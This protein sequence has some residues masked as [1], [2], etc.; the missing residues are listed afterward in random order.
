MSNTTVTITPIDNFGE[1]LDVE[2][3][4]TL[5]DDPPTFTQDPSINL[6]TNL[7]SGWNS[8][9]ISHF[10]QASSTYHP[11]R[12]DFNALLTINITHTYPI[13]RYIE[14][15]TRIQGSVTHSPDDGVSEPETLIDVE[16]DETVSQ[17]GY[18]VNLR[19]NVCHLK[20]G[21]QSEYG[22]ETVFED[23]SS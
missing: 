13:F 3:S 11:S 23:I 2:L 8:V 17:V 19:L 15:S 22:N 10:V 16:H 6:N 1:S 14:W 4:L 5:L 21:G 7:Y 9:S 20:R 18:P 12:T